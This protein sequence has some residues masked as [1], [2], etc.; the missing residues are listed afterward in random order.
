MQT[1]FIV[2]ALS[3]TF[4]KSICSTFAL[5]NHTKSERFLYSHPLIVCIYLRANVVCEY[6][7]DSCRNYKYKYFIRILFLRQLIN[8]R[9]TAGRRGLVWKYDQLSFI[10]LNLD[11]IKRGFVI[12]TK[13]HKLSIASISC[14]NMKF[15]FLQQL[16]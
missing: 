4:G 9:G 1:F 16:G 3:W 5:F 10:F 7:P 11:L 15:G 14:I 12:A 13:G 2:A 6:H 8:D